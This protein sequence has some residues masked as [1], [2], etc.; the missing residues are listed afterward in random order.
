[1]RYRSLP[2]TIAISILATTASWAATIRVPADSSTIQGAIV[3][4][5]NGDIV[6]VAPGTYV[7]NLDFLGK[8]IEVVA[9]DG[10]TLDGNGGQTVRFTRGEPAAAVLDGFTIT[11]GE[12]TVGAGVYISNGTPTI[13]NCR[14]EG[15]TALEGAGIYVTG[16]SAGVLL[17]G[18]LFDANFGSFGS[19]LS[20]RDCGTITIDE[21]RFYNHTPLGATVS[22]FNA[23][24]ASLRNSVLAE[25]RSQSSP[26]ALYVG[27]TPLHMTGCSFNDNRSDD[28]YGAAMYLERTKA[29]IIDCWFENNTNT[30]SGGGAA[31]LE[32]GS[33]IF[34]R[35]FFVRNRARGGDAVWASQMDSIKFERCTFE[36]NE[37]VDD[38]H[39]GGACV[40]SR[41]PDASIV[42]TEFRGNVS[43]SGSALGVS[44]SELTLTDTVF[45]DNVSRNP[46]GGAVSTWL[47]DVLMHRSLL[48]RN[49][50]LR[51]GAVHLSE[52]TSS[53]TSSIFASNQAAHGAAVLTQSGT[54][55]ITN[56]TFD[57]NRASVSGVGTIQID[58]GMLDIVN[59]IL[60]FDED[61]GD[62]AIRS[63]RSAVVEV[64]SSIVRGGYSG[65][66]NLDADPR[67]VNASL[68]DYHLRLD[69]PCIDAGEILP[70]PLPD[71]DGDVGPLD[72]DGD[73]IAQPDIGA[74]EMSLE[75]AARYGSVG[76]A[77]DAIEP[78]VFVNGLY[79]NER[80][81]VV[82]RHDWPL[83]IE[84]FAPSG[85]PEPARFVAYVYDAHPDSRTLSPQPFG[86][87]LAA[88]PTPLGGGPL[89]HVATFNNLGYEARLGT[90]DAPSKP[91]PSVLIQ[92]AR[93]L[94][95]PSRL[96]IQ[97][98]IED[99]GS[100]A[101]APVSLTNA[102]VVTFVE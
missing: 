26:A 38:Q 25:N 65:D 6:E 91:A 49:R 37:T 67:F 16:S 24:H 31:Y 35:C 87:G 13:R 7:E 48:I 59:T 57:K 78:V 46:G 1:M 27:R 79:G 80:R 10:A 77:G 70:D 95:F 14:F 83:R 41:I 88:F 99:A 32:G 45:V 30:D 85:G 55:S 71:F 17:S 86:L 82:L 36:A 64:A 33:A 22:I 101:D 34:D 61:R 44:V 81:E 90:P 68:G 97:G 96:T 62:V 43:S 15:N 60:S 63:G 21:S 92:R 9:P 98:F 50:G 42:G 100:N 56:C 3:S 2:L 94:S 89:M 12:A 18:C 20:A 40:L 58:S 39:P 23:E 47:C 73:G 76:A 52:S 75:V 4:A 53:I 28:F 11:G 93:P 66:G 72:G 8:A 74:D 69:S 102:V 19:A 54:T 29:D 51:G 84:M 5:R